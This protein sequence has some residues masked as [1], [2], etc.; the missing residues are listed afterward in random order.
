MKSRYRFKKGIK[1]QGPVCVI[2][3][4][5][6]K[7]GEYLLAKAIDKKAS[8]I[9]CQQARREMDL[10]SRNDEDGIPAFEGCEDDGDHLII[11]ESWIDGRNLN[12]WLKDKPSKKQKKNVFLQICSRI[13]K[14]HELGYLYMDLKPEHILIDEKGMVW[15]IDF[16]AVI[17]NGSKQVVLSNDLAIPPENGS[18][19]L[20]ELSDFPGLGSIHRLMFGPSSFSWTCL[21]EK[22]NQRF[23][24]IQ[25]LKKAAVP[26]F[27]KTALITAGLAALLIPL[28]M[29]PSASAEES[30]PEAEPILSKKAEFLHETTFESE[31]LSILE[32]PDSEHFPKTGPQ[33]E[34]MMN[35]VSLIADKN[36]LAA[37]LFTEKVQIPQELKKG[38]AWIQ[39]ALACRY[40]I[41]PSMFSSWIETI[42][43][44]D[45]RKEVSELKD[46][47]NAFLLSQT[48]PGSDDLKKIQKI[49]DGLKEN[50]NDE[51]LQLLLLQFSM[52]EQAKQKNF[53][54]IPEEILR[55]LE[56]KEDTAPLVQLYRLQAASQNEKPAVL[57]KKERSERI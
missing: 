50:Q 12:E 57:A 31:L 25:A 33:I 37:R 35:S 14:V 52:T 45:D 7:T 9:L 49:T 39:I 24:S 32:N 20:N 42:S 21:Q 16:N 30:H 48:S 54:R 44:M 55:Q 22:R 28:V 15:L 23:H 13:E 34:S 5:D 3:V 41:Q 51:E 43:S 53:C 56:K 10:L 26:G 36:P 27:R 47:L 38:K 17:P 8:S 4:L 1:N 6:L 11:Y 40:P 2:K 29:I 19:S 18:E 46:L